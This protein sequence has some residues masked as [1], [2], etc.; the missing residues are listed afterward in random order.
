[1]SLGGEIISSHPI[2]FGP[3][4]NVVEREVHLKNWQ[5]QVHFGK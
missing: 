4:A 5:T 3:A 2:I 1:M